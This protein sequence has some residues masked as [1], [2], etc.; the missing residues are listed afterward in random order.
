M[1]TLM[2][3]YVCA[4]ACMHD[5]ST[6]GSRRMR[7][8]HR[9]DSR[10]NASLGTFRST[11]A[12]GVRRR[13]TPRYFAKK[14]QRPGKAGIL[15]AAHRSTAGREFCESE[16]TLPRKPTRDTC[17]CDAASASTCCPHNSHRCPHISHRN[18]LTVVTYS[19]L[20]PIAYRNISLNRNR[21]RRDGVSG[22]GLLSVARSG[23]HVRAL[24]HVRVHTRAC[25]M[26]AVCGAYARM[27]LHNK[28]RA[29]A[30]L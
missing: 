13:R 4:C 6:D 8:Q 25:A 28:R 14:N 23:M 10:H 21:P 15:F 7:G 18:T 19:P 3:V 1:C 22:F 27:R 26:S 16:A 20:H 29:A 9:Q 17:R 12:V 30:R 2:R 5:C 11:H 24:M